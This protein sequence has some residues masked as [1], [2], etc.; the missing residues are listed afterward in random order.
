MLHEVFTDMFLSLDR[1]KLVESYID[2]FEG[3][4]IRPGFETR[5]FTLLVEQFKSW[6]ISFDKIS[7][8]APFN[9]SGFQ[10]T[11]NK[12]VCE[13]KLKELPRGEIIAISP[14]ASGYFE[15]SETLNYLNSLENLRGL[16]IGVSNKEQAKETFEIYKDFLEY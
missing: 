8:A 7:I 2:I 11:P 6:S 13:K 16:A 10:M 4:K 12:Q 15:P 1:K 3:Q 14:L 9:P 5:N